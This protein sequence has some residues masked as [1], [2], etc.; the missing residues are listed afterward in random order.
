MYSPK[1]QQHMERD[2]EKTSI[3]KRLQDSEAWKFKLLQ[4]ESTMETRRSKFGKDWSIISKS[5]NGTFKLLQLESTMETIR[6]VA[7]WIYTNHHSFQW[8]HSKN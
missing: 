2:L 4:P 5:Y 6:S 1:Q 8:E 7:T 3:Q